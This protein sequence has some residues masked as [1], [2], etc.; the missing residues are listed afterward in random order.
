V[1]KELRERFR[2]DHSTIQV[3]GGDE[4]TCRLDRPGCV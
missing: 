1:E 3:E 2:I 4:E